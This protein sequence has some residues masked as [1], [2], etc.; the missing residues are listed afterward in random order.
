[1]HAQLQVFQLSLHELPE[2]LVTVALGNGFILTA[3]LWGAFLAE[4]IDRRLRR[5]ATRSPCPPPRRSLGLPPMCARSSPV[6]DGS[7]RT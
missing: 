7:P 3:M 5:S 1:L 2:V 6:C 4:M